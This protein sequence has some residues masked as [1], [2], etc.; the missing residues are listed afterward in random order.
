MY[1]YRIPGDNPAAWVAPAMV[2]GTD[3]QAAATVLDPG[4]SP[5][6]AA[7]VDTSAQVPTVDPTKLPPL[8]AIPLT[9]D[10]YDAGRISVKLSS[11]PSAGSSLVVSENYFP[12]WTAE[13]DGKPATVVRADYNLI[14]VA[15][16]AGARAAA[17]ARPAAGA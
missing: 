4:F 5:A 1:L 17:R 14:G 15:L 13:V 2:R 11:P 6:R 12:G 7:I 3:E 9:I 8:S 16:P 10:R